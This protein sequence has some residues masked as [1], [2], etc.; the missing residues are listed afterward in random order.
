[1]LSDP[2]ALTPRH[3]ATSCGDAQVDQCVGRRHDRSTRGHAL[4]RTKIEKFRSSQSLYRIAL[5]ETKLHSHRATFWLHN[6]KHSST[7]PPSSTRARL[8]PC[9]T[10]TVTR[11]RRNKTKVYCSRQH[12][13]IEQEPLGQLNSACHTPPT[14]SEDTWN[15]TTHDRHMDRH[16][17]V[18]KRDPHGGH[19][20][21]RSRDA[22][23]P[24]PPAATH[25]SLAPQ[26]SRATQKE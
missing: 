11:S 3:V 4:T 8:I 26:L 17:C 9:H 19:D 22:L 15:G 24:T 18:T 1:V 12:R 7:K 20:P 14:P 16:D 23:N 10:Y 21:T 5:S 13:H 25:P 2:R 6:Y